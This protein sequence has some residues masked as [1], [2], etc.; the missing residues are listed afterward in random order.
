MK[1]GS[2]LHT[3]NETIDCVQLETREPHSGHNVHQMNVYHFAWI[4]FQ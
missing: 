1:T 3:Y 2:T 4:S